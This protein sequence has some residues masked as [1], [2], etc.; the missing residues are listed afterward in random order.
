MMNKKSNKIKATVIALTLV[1]CLA[2]AGV[3]AYFTD[4]A[5]VTNTFTIGEVKLEMTE[6]N[7]PG[8]NSDDVKDITP[9][10]TVQKDPTVTNTGINSEYV[11]V[12]VSVPYAENLVVANAAGEKQ[13]AADT[14]LFT[15]AINN[16]WTEISK[17]KNAD[18]KTFDYVYAYG[19]GTALSALPA[20]D[21]AET[22]EVKEDQTSALFNSITFVNAVEGQSLEKTSQDIKIDAYAIQADNLTSA[23]PAA[24]WNIICAQREVDAAIR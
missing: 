20:E 22:A 3:S 2:V 17:V 15:Y 9:N 4:A 21:N 24:V 23:D 18:D 10:K 6:P 13:A 8:N 1:A 19:S 5:D 12:T 7:Y 14:Q 16:G 11:F